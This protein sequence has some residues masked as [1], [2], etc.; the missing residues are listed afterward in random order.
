[1]KPKYM[2]DVDCVIVAGDID[3][4]ALTAGFR[5]KEFFNS[6]NGA[7]CCVVLGN[8]DFYGMD[9]NLGYKRWEEFLAE[10]PNVH[11][12]NRDSIMCGKYRIAGVS[13]WTDFSLD[14]T[15]E[16]SAA[17]AQLGI[18]DFT[19][20]GF[21]GSFISPPVMIDRHLKDRAYLQVLT[22]DEV[23]T[24]IVT[25]FV[26]FREAIDEMWRGSKLNAYFTTDQASWLCRPNIPAV[27][28]GHTHSTFDQVLGGT[29]RGVCN[30]R[31]YPG[32]H[33]AR[34]HYIPQVIDLP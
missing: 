29:T 25:H 33:K 2:E 19:S 26:P 12:L 4:I 22:Q 6:L 18:S 21:R 23:P 24:V 16:I 14:G 32:E 31:G 9:L 11:L 28:F 7:L 3:S 20:I 10:W 15:P 5:A 1:M 34:K 8:H 30:P 13:L 27:L 17:A